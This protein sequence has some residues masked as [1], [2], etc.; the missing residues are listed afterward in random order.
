MTFSWRTRHPAV[1]RVTPRGCTNAGCRTQLPIKHKVKYLGLCNNS[2]CR[3]FRISVT[4]YLYTSFYYRSANERH[5]TSKTACS[6]CCN[7]RTVHLLLFCTIT[8]KCTIISQI[9]TL[10]HVSTLLCHPQEVRS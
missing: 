2:D 7:T 4:Q 1:N 5:G 3:N 9:I 8:N 6:F 10:L